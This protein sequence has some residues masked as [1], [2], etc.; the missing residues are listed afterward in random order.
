[1]VRHGT[2]YATELQKGL[3]SYLQRK[4]VNLDTLRGMLAVPNDASTAEYE[5]NGYVAA[6]E[7]AKTTYGS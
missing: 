7:K 5:R 3:E 1:M 4:E 2:G 6:L